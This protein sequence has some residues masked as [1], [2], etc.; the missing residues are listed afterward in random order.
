M[1]QSAIGAPH[2]QSEN[3]VLAPGYGDLE[4]VLPRPGTYRL[5][6]LGTAEDAWVVNSLDHKVSLHDLMTSKFTLLS[7]IYTNCSDV[8]GCPVATHVMGKIQS[9]LRS[10]EVL[11]DHVRLISF[12]FDPDNDTAEIL[13]AYAANFRKPESDWHFVTSRSPEVLTKV[14]SDYNQ[15]V[16][17][18]TDENGK[19]LGSISHMLRVYLIDH[20]YQIR[21]VYSVS[22]LHPDT[23]MNDIR[24][25]VLDNARNR[26][27]THK[28]RINKMS[29]EP[30]YEHQEN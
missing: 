21:N 6:V 4:F 20:R 18:D 16:I 25:I 12:S 19:L 17:R 7:F 29:K 22:F 2:H 14:L 28:Q 23:V 27:T 8:N 30:N 10:D 24:T 9:R 15:F 13:Q 3:V 26:E 5:P 11:K 1:A